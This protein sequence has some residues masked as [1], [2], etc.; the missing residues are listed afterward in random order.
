[1]IEDRL[2][3]GE[4]LRLE[5]IA[6]A[7]QLRPQRD[8]GELLDNADL[9]AAWIENPEGAADRRTQRA[10]GA[11]PGGEP[12]CQV[13]HGS[14]WQEIPESGGRVLRCS[15]TPPDPLRPSYEAPGFA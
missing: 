14:G 4:R 10:I 1:M 15:C 7:Q 12:A 3:H 8:V 2:T 6:Q 11:A 5:A 13:C 9:I